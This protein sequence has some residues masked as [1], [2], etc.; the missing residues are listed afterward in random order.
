MHNKNINSKDTNK[1]EHYI[2]YTR[3]VIVAE[4]FVILKNWKHPDV[5]L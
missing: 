4:L 3:L 2:V 1:Y 5:H